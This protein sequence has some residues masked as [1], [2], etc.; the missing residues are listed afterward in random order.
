MHDR[1][2]QK[3]V[4]IRNM[5]MKKVELEKIECLLRGAVI[6]LKDLNE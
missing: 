1:P 2:L 6:I 5:S 3:W 4:K